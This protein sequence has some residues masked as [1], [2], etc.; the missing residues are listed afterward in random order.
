MH[1]CLGLLIVAF[2]MMIVD[3]V[4]IYTPLVEMITPPGKARPSQF[5]DYHN[6]SKWINA[7]ARSGTPVA[8][9]VTSRT[10]ST[11]SRVS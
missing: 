4:W 1:L 8:K 6:G 10:M 9:A 5:V 7:A 11:G 2:A 3:Y